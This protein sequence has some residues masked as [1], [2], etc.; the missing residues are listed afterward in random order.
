MILL[1][2]KEIYFN[3]SG[4]DHV[5]PSVVIYLLQDFDDIFSK[6]TLNRLPPLK[7]IEHHIDFVLRVVIPNQPIYRSN[8]QKTKELQ[9]KIDELMMK[10]YIRESM[11]IC[12]VSVLLVPKKDGT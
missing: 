10:G 4:L 12:D 2:Y 6:D 1:V 9:K 5:V 8:P 7:G 3:S 11:S